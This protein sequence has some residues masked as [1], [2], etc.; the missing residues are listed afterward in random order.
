MAFSA[1]SVDGLSMQLQRTGSVQV[2][3]GMCTVYFNLP[4]N[5]LYARAPRSLK[6]TLNYTY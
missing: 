3:V 4:C 6:T 2:Q 5:A 1:R